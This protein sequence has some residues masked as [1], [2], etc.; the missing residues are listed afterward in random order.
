MA[1]ALVLAPSAAFAQASPQQAGA[2]A[3]LTSSPDEQRTIV[4]TGS[5]IRGTPEDAAL[6]V[7]VFTSDDLAKQGV[8]SPLEFIKE[9]PSVGAVLGDT[10][11][12]ATSAQAYQGVGSINLRG[13]GPQRTL[14]LV[15]GKRTIQT[16]GAGFVD[17]QLIPLFALERVEILK[18]GAGSTYGSDAIA[19]V[20]NFI[21]RSTFT[22]VEVQGDYSIIDGSDDNYS[23]S[24]LVGFEFGDANL[25]IG[26]GWQH[27]SELP[28]TARDYTQTNYAVNPSAYSALS[29]PGLFAVTYLN[30][31]TGGLTTQTRPDRG[32]NDLGGFQDGAQC[33]FTYIPYDNIVEDE[34]RYQVY[35]QFTADLSD[36]VRFQADAM[37]ARTDLESINYSP[38][39]PPTQG[40]NGSGFISAFTTSPANPGL[41]AF[42]AQQGLPGS[43]AGMPIVRVTNVLFR[44][45]GYLGNPR[46]TDRGAGEGF[47]STDAFRVSGGFDIELN[48]SLTLDLDATFWD[49]DRE[50]FAPGIVGS[51]L[52]AA[53]N[54]LGGPNC[55]GTTPGANGCVFFNPFVNAGPENPA[56]NLT[57][58]FYVAGAEN[59]PEL[60]RWL[61]VPNGV[62][63][64]ESQ[65]V[66]DAVVSGD[67]GFQL[68][69]G[70]A[71][72]AVGFQYRKTNFNSR[73]FN[74][75]SN[76][77]INPCFREG[78]R[79]CVG[80]STEGVGP[81]IFLGGS[82]PVDVDQS[83]YAIFGELQL[84]VTDQLEVQA[85]IRYEDYGGA[86][87]STIN[88]KGSARFEATDW[89]TLRGSVGTT[90][91]GPIPSQVAPISVT[92]LQGFTAAG[93]NYKSLDIFGNPNDL[94]PETAFTY[95]IGAILDAPIMGGGVVFSVDYWSIAL[96]DRITTTPGDAIASFVGNGQT[97]GAAPVDCSSPLANLITFSGNTCVQG[98]TN[99]LD[100][101]RVRTDW[102]NGPDVDV[103]GIDF[104]LNFD[105]P[106]GQ[107]LDLAFGA[108]GSWYLDYT[109]ADF[110]LQ[111]VVVEPS[112][113]AVGL[114]NYFRDPNTVPEWRANGFVNL[115]WNIANLRYSV[116]HIDG[117]SDDRCINRTPCFQTSQGP[118]DYGVESGSFTQHDIS[119]T[120][121]LN[122]AGVEAQLQ[123]AIKNFTD[124]EPA[125]AQ[126]PLGYNPFVGNAIGRHYRI[127]LR[128]R[129]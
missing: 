7:D 99:G 3:N 87:G 52:Q 43:T 28:T 35:A 93:G 117:V 107:D 5:L 110:E 108:A 13:L 30:T 76:L 111:G 27:R 33:R 86:V 54:G 81:F 20:A 63:E 66:F 50:R 53:L 46:D 101:S 75:I 9:L 120:L 24:G 104:A 1:G 61:Q 118:T 49:A 70:N 47:A 119:L 23:L 121:D 92:A 126:L 84:P 67:T 42:L 71:A 65:Y 19:G 112:Y 96:K 17:T 124:A 31:A 74:D 128:T 44:P 39:F 127:G 105:F 113:D 59:S 18:D 2:D 57:N 83:V 6:P 106:L 25:V 26:A 80:T 16:P 109:F 14:V 79:S 69:G 11:Q 45:F 60:V 12:F 103:S 114:G 32:C 64:E 58:P 129:F 123:G 68:P 48:D 40:P 62:V 102:V 56:L 88:P 82:R 116:S 4:V 125:E 51:R 97:T 37:W 22:G 72:F 115:A 41:P 36:R 34:D 122:L 100:I 21:T 91:R 95:N 73:P 15:N 55:Q 8:D 29:T 90:F 85:A 98:T 78:D 89:L 77:N 94:G 38:A 10:N